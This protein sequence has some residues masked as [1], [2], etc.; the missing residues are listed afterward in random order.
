MT[1]LLTGLP[2]TFNDRLA[3]YYSQISDAVRRNAHHDHRRAL[4]IEFLRKTFSIEVDEIE[5][6]LKVKAAEARGRIDAFYKYVIFEVK[7]DLERERQDAIRELKKY[8]ESRNH[9]SDYIAAVT[10]GLS[11]EIYDYNPVSKEASLVRIFQIEPDK[12]QQV[13]LELDELLASGNKI[14]PSSYDIVGRFGLKSTT[15]LRA[16]QQLL[17]A[18]TLVEEDTAV[19]VKFREWNSLLSKVYGNA[20]GDKGLFLRHTYLTILSRA[21]VTMA[22]FPKAHRGRALYR[23]LLTESFFAIKTS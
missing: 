15:F 22:L 1:E 21:I 6:E 12:P 2:K 16:N 7:I 20:V 10:D 11:F 18:F 13:Y 8:F 5:L 3:A 9:P 19:A 17:D 23:N 4:L 14:P